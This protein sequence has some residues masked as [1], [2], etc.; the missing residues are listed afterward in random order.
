ML[1]TFMVAKF[2]LTG[3]VN[4]LFIY[5]WNLPNVYLNGL[6]L[7][8]LTYIGIYFCFSITWLLYIIGFLCIIML[9]WQRNLFADEGFSI[10]IFNA[11]ASA[12][13]EKKF[14]RTLYL[15]FMI[16]MNA[17]QLH[18][19]RMMSLFTCRNQEA[20]LII[21]RSLQWAPKFKL[22]IVKMGNGLYKTLN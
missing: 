15:S 5:L 13:A 3:L 21:K 6:T 19:V 16:N 7:P 18:I 2:T 4:N 17:F 1:Y 11:I 8:E 14:C 9:L 12:T 10:W 20:Y 22:Y